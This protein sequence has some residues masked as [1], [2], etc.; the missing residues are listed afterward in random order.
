MLKNWRINAVFSLML[1]FSA[2]IIGRLVY[3]QIIQHDLYSALANGQ[4]GAFKPIKGQRGRIF[5]STGQLL[6]TNTKGSYVFVCPADIEEKEKTAEKLAEILEIKKEAVLD[7][8][9]KNTLFEKLKNNLSEKEKITLEEKEIHGVYIGETILRSYPYQKTASQVAGFLGGEQ[10]GQ[11][12][13]EGFYDDVLR[14][15]E[16]FFDSGISKKIYNGSDIFLTIDYNLQ[17]AAE[18][19]LKKA[20][21]DVDIEGGQIIVMDPNTGKILVLAE[22]GG[23]DPN[24]YF[25]VE[26]FNVFQNSAVQKLFEPGSTFKPITM[27]VALDQG[28]IT[29]YTT[30]IDEGKIKIGEHIIE[31]YSGRVFGKRTMTEVLEKSI[32]TGAVFAERQAGHNIFLNYLERFGF[33]KPTGIDL[34][35][36]VFSEN[37]SLKKGYEINFATAS[38]GQGIEITPMQL[39]RGFAVI[40]NGGKLVKPYVADKIVNNEGRV[41]KTAPSISSEQIISTETVSKLTAMLVSV[42]ENGYASSGKIEGYYIAAKTGTAQIPWSALGINEK[43]YSKKTWQSFIGFFPAFAPRFVLLVKLDNPKT[44]TAE[45]SA[46]PIFKEMARYIINYYAVPPD[47]E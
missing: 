27:A 36:E 1:L 25:E 46:V 43:G 18:N 38:F 12:G 22:F 28:K 37:K 29:P 5:F 2:V 26:D 23:F 20:K 31:N 21:E 13:V 16:E 35:G 47:Y 17:F 24:N 7:K 15:E 44:N 3:I 41:I 11:Y 10:I 32:N 4:Q 39:V 42:V 14:G 40:A 33:F 45:Y 19:L 8:L 6:A 9:N 30:Y 34:Q